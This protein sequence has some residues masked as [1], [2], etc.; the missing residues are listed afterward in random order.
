MLSVSHEAWFTSS[1]KHKYGASSLLGDDSIVGSRTNSAELRAALRP[2]LGKLLPRILRACHDPNKQTREQ[3]SSL[4]VGLT[5]G[6]SEARSAITQHLLP[7]IDI[8]IED[9]TNKLWRARAGACGALSEIL[10]GRS[11][12]D[13]GGGP[14]VLDDDDIHTRTSSEHL[15]AGIRLLRL[16]RYESVCRHPAL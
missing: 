6:G 9:C 5:G 4:W 10:V 8:L 14:P 16:F 11:W 1:N 15:T 12:D 2:H 13:L 3:M 7:T